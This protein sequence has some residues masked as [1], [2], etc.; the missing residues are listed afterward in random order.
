MEES[1]YNMGKHPPHP[2]PPAGQ[3]LPLPSGDKNPSPPHTK[4][5]LRDLSTC[6]TVNTTPPMFTQMGLQRLES[7]WGSKGRAHFPSFPWPYADG[8]G[9]GQKSCLVARRLKRSA[10]EP[11]VTRGFSSPLQHTLNP[12]EKPGTSVSWKHGTIEKATSHSK[13]KQ[14]WTSENMRTTQLEH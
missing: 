14:W 5:S 12:A 6:S 10:E 3:S 9:L 2:T 11:R 8:A 1:K 13:E 7:I 4:H